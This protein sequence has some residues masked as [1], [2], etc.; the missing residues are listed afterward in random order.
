MGQALI[1]LGLALPVSYVFLDRS[2]MR[3][4]LW[5]RVFLEWQR[6]MPCTTYFEPASRPSQRD[7][8]RFAHEARHPPP[9]INLAEDDRD[10]CGQFQAEAVGVRGGDVSDWY[11]EGADQ[12]DYGDNHDRYVFEEEDPGEFPVELEA[13]AH[14]V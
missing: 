9:Q 7:A 11:E 14:R 5:A 3:G 12:H 4:L 13:V 10:E 2:Q 1:W 6:V 8:Q